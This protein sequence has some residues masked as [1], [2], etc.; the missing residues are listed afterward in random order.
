MWVLYI[1]SFLG[2]SSTWSFNQNDWD[3]HLVS[4]QKTWRAWY[5]EDDQTKVPR[6]I[7]FLWDV[8]VFPSCLEASQRSEPLLQ[9]LSPK[10]YHW[11]WW[12][13]L[14]H[15]N[16]S[17]IASKKNTAPFPSWATTK[18]TQI[19]RG[20]SPGNRESGAEG[21]NERNEWKDQTFG[22][23]NQASWEMSNW[24]ANQYFFEEENGPRY[25]LG[26]VW[27]HFFCLLPCIGPVL[28]LKLSWN[29]IQLEAKVR[30]ILNTV[31]KCLYLLHCHTSSW[32][33]EKRVFLHGPFLPQVGWSISMGSWA[34]TTPD[35]GRMEGDEYRAD[36]P[37]IAFQVRSNSTFTYTDWGALP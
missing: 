3:L 29:G 9:V 13:V 4:N 35:S 23:E 15:T 36:L 31:V 18:E 24:I 33:S 21:K 5:E 10:A 1:N 14:V 12:F 37:N 8:S 6:H 27:S 30:T 16:I 34:N 17:P 25:L 7:C 20:R 22:G 11:V 19:T 2:M 26:V 28:P 32:T